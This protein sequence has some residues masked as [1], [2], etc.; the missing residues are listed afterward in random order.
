MQGSQTADIVRA[1]LENELSILDYLKEDLIN[2]AALARKILPK[3][4]QKNRNATIESISIAIKRYVAN[5]KDRGILKDLKAVVAHSQITVRDNVSHLTIERT[6]QNMQKIQDASKKIRWD[7]DEICLVNQGA[8]EMTVVADQKNI[9]LFGPECKNGLALLTVKES[10]YD[11]KGIDVPGLYAY[12]ISSLSRRSIN[13]L[14]VISTS[15]QVSFLLEEKDL[16][17]GYEILKACIEFCKR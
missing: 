6:F 2:V 17:K 14:E 16:T 9:Q 1:E 5:Q 7:K 13:I 4:K 8:G 11:I 10:D 15:S 12:F 3:V